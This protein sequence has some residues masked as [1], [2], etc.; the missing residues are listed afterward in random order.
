V[1]KED[2]LVLETYTYNTIQLHVKW[3]LFYSASLLNTSP[4]FAELDSRLTTLP[5]TYNKHLQTHWTWNFIILA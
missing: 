4:H 1:L 5:S 3:N 2:T